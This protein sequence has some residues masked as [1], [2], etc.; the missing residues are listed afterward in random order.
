MPAAGAVLGFLHYMPA[1]RDYYEVLSV[2][3]TA[4][5]E[6]IKKAYRRAALK[7]HPDKN[8]GDKEAEVKF[9]E[10]AEAYEVLSDPEKR[11]RYDQYGH[12]GLRGTAVRD[13]QHMQYEDIF[14]MFND[15]FGGMGGFPGGRRGGAAGP[16]QTRGY[17]LETQVEV[18]LQD[19]AQGC[20]RTIDFTRQDICEHCGGSGAKPGTKKRI[21]TTCG[22]RGQVAQRGFGGM[23]QMITTCPSCMGQGAVVDEACPQCDGAGRTPKKRELVVKIPA[24]IHDGQAVR[25]RGEGEPGENG[26]PRGDLHVYVRV[27]EHEFFQRDENNLVMQLPVSFAQAALGADVEVPTLFG[28]SSIRVPAG[29]PYG[30]V[31]RVRGM[32]LPDLRGGPSGDLLVQVLI[33]VPRKL[34]KRQEQLLRE[35]AETEQQNVLPAQK[36]FL[37]KLKGYLVGEEP[38]KKDQ[39]EA[40]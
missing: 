40:S 31:L 34:N 7:Y 30:H 36:S 23:F 15:I 9:K 27:K 20:E 35:Y 26:G 14:S 11:A 1:K 24:G 33:E 17:D 25:V 22:G 12:E 38:A 19:V 6:E 32:G 4:S 16:R 3:K 21:C 10:A 37:E 2:T 29:T 5:V 18:T 8:P 39:R 28:K 13:Y